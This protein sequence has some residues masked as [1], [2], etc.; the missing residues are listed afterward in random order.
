MIIQPSKCPIGREY[1]SLA[2]AQ[3]D[4]EYMVQEGMYSYMPRVWRCASGNHFHVGSRGRSRP[5]CDT[6][7][8]EVFLT[9]R[10]ADLELRNTAVKFR[11]GVDNRRECRAYPCGEHWHLTSMEVWDGKEESA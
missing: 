4:A 6:A 9:K 7:K 1:R 3:D 10:L 2:E 8:K 11:M 5:F